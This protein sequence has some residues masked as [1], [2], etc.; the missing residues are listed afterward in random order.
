[1]WDGGLSRVYE[2]VISKV[3]SVPCAA[4]VTVSMRVPRILAILCKGMIIAH[5]PVIKFFHSKH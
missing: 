2:Q 4:L 5:L 1:M 3:L